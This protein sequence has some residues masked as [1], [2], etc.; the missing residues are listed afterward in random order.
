MNMTG[1]TVVTVPLKKL[2]RFIGTDT[3]PYHFVLRGIHPNVEVVTVHLYAI[4][5]LF[6]LDGLSDDHHGSEQAPREGFEDLPTVLGSPL[7]GN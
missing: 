6:F 1:L 2:Y 4:K 5:C 3:V 7:A